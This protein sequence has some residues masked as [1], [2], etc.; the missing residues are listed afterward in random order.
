MNLPPMKHIIITGT[1]QYGKRVSEMVDI[2]PP[3]KGTR[4]ALWPL[5]IKRLKTWRGFFVVGNDWF[6]DANGRIAWFI[7]IGS[8]KLIMGKQMKEWQTVTKTI[9]TSIGNEP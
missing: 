5:H 6:G 7:R 9:F 2:S 8:I 1:D 3:I 4:Y